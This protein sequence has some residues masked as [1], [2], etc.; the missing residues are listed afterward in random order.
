MP[1]EDALDL[2]TFAPREVALVVGDYLEAAH[3]RG[4]TEVRLIHGRGIGVQ[5]KIVRSL[6]ARHPLV[7]GYAD[8]PP[9]RGGAG[10]TLVRLRP[11]TR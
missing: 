9:E 2:H 3:A 6:L 11:H 10:A 1:I 5:R 8:A 7:A 4:F